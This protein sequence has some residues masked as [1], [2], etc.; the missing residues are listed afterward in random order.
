MDPPTQPLVPYSPTATMSS[1]ISTVPSTNYF[2]IKSTLY[3]DKGVGIHQK[4]FLHTINGAYAKNICENKDKTLQDSCDVMDKLATGDAPPEE[5][6]AHF[7]AFATHPPL[8]ASQAIANVSFYS[9]T[10]HLPR[11][12]CL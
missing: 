2:Y 9:T 4:Q 11:L 1:D 3:N 10:I 8:Q 12:C 6:E 7:M 5:Q